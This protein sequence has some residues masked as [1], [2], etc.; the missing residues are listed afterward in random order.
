VHGT[1]DTT[2][3]LASSIDFF[4]KLNAAGVPSAL[5]AIQGAAH[6]F[7][8]GALDAVEVMAQSI[9]LFLDRLLVNPRPYPAFG[10]G[11]GGRRPDSGPPGT[12]RPRGQ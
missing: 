4:N 1:G 6:A 12:E 2:V 11:G 5:T 10:P 7:D 3:P 9:D 8:N